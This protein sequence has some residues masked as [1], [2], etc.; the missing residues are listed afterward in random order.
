MTQDNVDN[1][2]NSFGKSFDADTWC[3]ATS[4]TI[5]YSVSV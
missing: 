4:L 3:A 1:L 2:N 5:S